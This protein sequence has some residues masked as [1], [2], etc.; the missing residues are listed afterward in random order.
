MVMEKTGQTGNWQHRRGIDRVS[1]EG[2]K[3]ILGMKMTLP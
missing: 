1:S 3:D 2:S